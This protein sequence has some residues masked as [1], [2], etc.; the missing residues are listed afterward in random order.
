MTSEEPYS[1]QSVDQAAMRKLAA[2][3][4]MLKRKPHLAH[5]VEEMVAAEAHADH[6]AHLDGEVG[7]YVAE[8]A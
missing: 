8:A 7:A 6:A 2:E 5:P 3:R 1:P 4:T